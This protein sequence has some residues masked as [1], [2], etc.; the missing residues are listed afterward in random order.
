M[1][2]VCLWFNNVLVR[3]KNDLCCFLKFSFS[4][5]HCSLIV[6]NLPLTRIELQSIHGAGGLYNLTRTRYLLL[7][8]VLIHVFVF[9]PVVVAGAV[10]NN[11][12]IN[13]TVVPLFFALFLFV[14]FL[15]D[16][17]YAL[18]LLRQLQ[19]LQS[20]GH[21]SRTSASF[22]RKLTYYIVM[23]DG[24]LL[25]LVLIEVL[26]AFVPGAGTPTEALV[27]NACKQVVANTMVFRC[28]MFISKKPPQRETSHTALK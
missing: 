21:T 8:V 13:S 17:T 20:S 27:L 7:I 1:G 12:T 6:S 23:I 25:L 19:A 24:L 9:V 2:C 16:I 11:N 18:R 5:F 15:L 10:L 28:L 3:L 22:L 4:L 14:L 26:N